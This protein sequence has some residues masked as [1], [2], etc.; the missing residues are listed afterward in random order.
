MNSTLIP[1]G[2]HDVF[3]TNISSYLY[4]DHINNLYRTCKDMKEQVDESGTYIYKQ[5]CLHY[6]PHSVDD[7]PTIDV[8]GDQVWYKEGK[9]HRYGDLP[10]LIRSNG[11]QAWYKEGKSHRDGDLPA[12]IRSDGD[13]EWYKE[14]ERH[15]D[16]DLPAIISSSGHQYWYKEGICQRF[17]Q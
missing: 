7:L 4:I 1:L 5:I 6:Q 15:R 12:I 13:Q 11:T 17:G 2:L 9:C 3:S 10:A 16:G 8:F 14:G